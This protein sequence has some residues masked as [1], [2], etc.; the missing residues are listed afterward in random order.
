MI[1]N[2]LLHL[3]ELFFAACFEAL[4]VMKDE[5]VI[6]PEHQLVLDV[7]DSVLMTINHRQK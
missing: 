2:K 4:R 7:V 6:A 3:Q 5:F 1:C